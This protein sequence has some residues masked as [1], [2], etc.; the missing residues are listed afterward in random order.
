MDA[1]GTTQDF[2][3]E[4]ENSEIMRQSFEN[5]ERQLEESHVAL[6]AESR[7]RVLSEEYHTKLESELRESQ[8][9]LR[10]VRNCA[11]FFNTGL[12]VH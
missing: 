3:L 2:R 9:K 5:L 7:A 4:A 1:E 11:N 10:E 12:I 8:L 6:K